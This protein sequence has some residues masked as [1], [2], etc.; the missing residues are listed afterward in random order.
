MGETIFE[1]IHS[2]PFAAT[3]GDAD[4]V[5]LTG[6]ATLSTGPGIGVSVVLMHNLLAPVPK[7][8]LC[9]HQSIGRHA[10]NPNG[11]NVVGPF[12][13]VSIQAT[14]NLTSIVVQNA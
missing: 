1:E 13:A 4:R 8:A 6:R 14:A 11:I 5:D 7:P 2:L 12:R 3:Y 10:V 9:R